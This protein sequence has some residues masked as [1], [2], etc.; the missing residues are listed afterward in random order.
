MRVHA[1]LSDLPYV[2]TTWNRTRSLGGTV[3]TMMKRCYR[4]CK[5][6]IRRGKKVVSNKQDVGESW[7]C[8]SVAEHLLIMSEASGA[9]HSCIT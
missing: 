2:L 8:S 9:V 7:G 6:G 5:K 1:S 4:R 3:L